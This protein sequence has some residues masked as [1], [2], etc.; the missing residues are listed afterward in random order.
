M[1][2]SPPSAAIVQKRSGV[3][4]CF[5]FGPE[6]LTQ[7][8]GRKGGSKTVRQYAYAAIPPEAEFRSAVVSGG[9]YRIQLLLGFL[10]VCQLALRPDAPLLLLGLAALESLLAWGVYRVFRR[11]LELRRTEIPVGDSAIVILNDRRHEQIVG[12]L[13]RRRSACLQALA[14]LRP[15]ETRRQNLRRLRALAELG[16]IAPSQY[17]SFQQQLLPDVDESFLKPPASAGDDVA[18]D[19]RRADV[20]IRFQFGEQRVR[21]ERS[22]LSG[23]SSWPVP[24][25]D[26]PPIE[27]LDQSQVPS[28]A[29]RLATFAGGLAF[30]CVGLAVLNS[31]A[32]DGLHVRRLSRD[33]LAVLMVIAVLAPV[34]AVLRLGL[35]KFRC[36]KLRNGFL[37]L[38]GA[39]HE[40]ILTELT[41][42]R[43]HALRALAEVDP[44]LDLE[45]Q[46]RRLQALLKAGVLSPDELG[47]RMRKAQWMQERLD[48]DAVAE[49]A[50][51]APAF[52]LH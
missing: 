16:A 44:L 29:I 30:C 21:C 28:F 2:T 38:H 39:D 50:P 45:A 40:A 5:E 12:E 43:A 6:H 34:G 41:Q 14:I 17:W 48:L 10:L 25:A 35:A 19:Q 13:L 24:Y 18:F 1:Q 51:R 42:R 33:V 37:V 8:I 49:P 9:L 7:T 47:E 52:V 4:V 27:R 36:T 23:G 22:D 20:R 32:L 11:R 31:G 46:R 15:D 26:L 3:S